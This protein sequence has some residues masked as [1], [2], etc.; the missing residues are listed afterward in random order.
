M[1]KSAGAGAAADA[2][3]TQLERHL[4]LSPEVKPKTTL[5]SFSAQP[6][7]TVLSLIPIMT[8]H[9]T[10]RDECALDEWA[11]KWNS[12]KALSRGIYQRGGGGC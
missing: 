6:E 10:H 9:L 5:V 8:P 12:F 3:M 4:R 2:D 11:E 7:M 1:V